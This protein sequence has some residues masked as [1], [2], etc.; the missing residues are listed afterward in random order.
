MSFIAVGLVLAQAVTPLP[1]GHSH[2]DYWRPRP[3]LDALELGFCSVEAD[4]FLVDGELRVGHD[5]KE[6]KPGATLSRLYLEPLAARARQNGG[7]IY[8]NGPEFTL[9]VDIK[10]EGAAVFEVLRAELRRF[11]DLVSRRGQARAVRVIVSGDR[12]KIWI[13]ADREGWMAIDGR[14][15]DVG[16]GL[17][18]SLVPL[19]SEN[20]TL[21]FRWNGIGEMPAG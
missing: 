16:T 7:R 8:P 20:W 4:I 21:H 18:S 17:P 11:P 3:L 10:R 9:L 2:N 1:Q 13:E 5:L 15:P 12:P 14:W 6:I 19:I